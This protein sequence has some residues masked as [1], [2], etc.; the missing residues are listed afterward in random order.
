MIPGKE[1]NPQ[2]WIKSRSRSSFVPDELNST[3]LGETRGFLQTDEMD[4]GDQ[5][6]K[7]VKNPFPRRHRG[8][9]VVR[10]QRHRSVWEHRSQ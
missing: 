5:E 9:E 2:I 6:M 3:L 7:L 8:Q 10:G 4:V 1:A